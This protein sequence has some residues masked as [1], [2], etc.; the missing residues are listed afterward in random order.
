M[1]FTPPAPDV[2]GLV[3]V[4]KRELCDFIEYSIHGPYGSDEKWIADKKTLVSA[5]HQNREG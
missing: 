4:P 1:S 2:I 5:A 3:A